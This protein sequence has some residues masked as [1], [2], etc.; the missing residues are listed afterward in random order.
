MCSRCQRFCL[1]SPSLGFVP[2]Q[3]ISLPGYGFDP[4]SINMEIM[5]IKLSVICT[6]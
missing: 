6:A 2:L 3:S 5:R 1:I 4:A